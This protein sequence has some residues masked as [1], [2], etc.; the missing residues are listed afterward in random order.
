[1]QF[2]INLALSRIP[3]VDLAP[4]LLFSQ[5]DDMNGTARMRP[6][7]LAAS[8]AVGTFLQS[9]NGAETYVTRTNWVDKAITNVVEVRMP[10][11][12]FVNEYHTNWVEQ[13]HTNVVTRDV[14]RKVV[15]DFVHT[16]V[17]TH[18]STNY[19]NKSE[20]RTVYFDVL[21]TNFVDH[22][23]TNVKALH[24][25]N[26][27]AINLVKTNFVDRYRTNWQTLN[28]TNFQT[29]LVMKT[30]WVTQ[31]VTNFVQL[32]LPARSAPASS[33][34]TPVAAP[35]S[36]RQ[37]SKA[38]IRSADGPI[39]EGAKTSSN[40]DNNLVEVLLK[41]RWPADTAGTPSV[42][43]WKIERE[44]GA[45]MSVGQEQTF[46]KELAIGTYKIEVR[47]KSDGPV[48]VVRGTLV[49]TA[50]EVVVRQKTTAKKLVSANN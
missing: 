17:I 40:S 11:N 14:P 24:L 9:L 29:V 22:F 13:V 41:V 3:V 15:V 48:Q 49:I 12:V 50:N 46:K 39:L 30:N 45:F 25:T 38:S 44:D 32:D 4:G 31:P 47:L 27:I 26:D 16:N 43:Q 33:P 2:R 8:L 42:Q 18:Y 35:K 37:V 34:S 20:E 7:G 10:K 21:S 28:F 5:P 19:I 6:V 36:E 1:L 23:R